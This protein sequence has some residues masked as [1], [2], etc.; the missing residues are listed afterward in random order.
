MARCCEACGYEAYLPHSQSDPVRDAN[1]SA[2]EVA[3]TDLRKLNVADVVVAYLGWPSLGVGAEV[4]HA[5]C[6]RIFV[7]ALTPCNSN[8]SR[9]LRGYIDSHDR[10]KM[11]TFE[12]STDLDGVLRHELMRLSDRA[13]LCESA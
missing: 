9:F 5:L 6:R 4:A 1:K 2:R 7:L 3:D 10:G 13:R 8:V 12:D 11:V